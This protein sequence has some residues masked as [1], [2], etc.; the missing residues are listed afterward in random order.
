MRA[1]IALKR[2]LSV[3][4]M[5]TMHWAGSCCGQLPLA[6]EKPPLV[7]VPAVPALVAVAFSQCC[8]TFAAVAPTPVE[9]FVSR[10]PAIVHLASALEKSPHLCSA[11]KI[12]LIM[13]VVDW[14]LLRIPTEHLISSFAFPM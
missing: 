5:S 6:R 11:F 2:F 12:T 8:A 4:F 9:A 13:P 3:S 10:I 1:E 7:M 14:T